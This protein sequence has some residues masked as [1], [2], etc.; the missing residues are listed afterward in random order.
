[1]PG[2]GNTRSRDIAQAG[3]L[4][5]FDEHFGG[6]VCCYCGEW[7]TSLDHVMPISAAARLY[8][9]IIRDRRSYQHGLKL[10]PCCADCNRRL[11]NRFFTNV[12]DKRKA[13]ARLLRKKHKRM[14]GTYD[15]Q[16]DELDEMGRMLHTYIESRDSKRKIV[17]DRIKFARSGGRLR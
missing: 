16:E 4:Y 11:A 15:W 17:E 10:V 5:T 12:T 13:L 2:F 14:L 8:E 9:E 1:M 3:H 7:A 6:T